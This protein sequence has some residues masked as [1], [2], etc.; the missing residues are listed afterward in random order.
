MSWIFPKFFWVSG[1][2]R[3]TLVVVA[4]ESGSSEGLTYGRRGPSANRRGRGGRRR[5]G[6]AGRRADGRRGRGRRG[7]RSGSRRGRSGGESSRWVASSLGTGGGPSAVRSLR[8]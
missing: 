6:R 7:L 5:G 4:M 2:I 3:R 8:D 1:T